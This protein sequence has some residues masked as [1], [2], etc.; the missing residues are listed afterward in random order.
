MAPD[1][2]IDTTA[3]NTIAVVSRDPDT[4]QILDLW[5]RH[6]GYAVCV[7]ADPDRVLEVARAVR[8]KLV[9]TNYPTL[10][11]SG[12]TVVEAIR[13]S[14]ELA[15][16]LVLSLTSH[17]SPHDLAAATTAGVDLSV[18]MPVPLSVLS[19]EVIRLIGPPAD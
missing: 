2:E 14:P 16:T 8:P 15:Q 18:P 12:D 17:V 1:V 13:G 11:S 10:L 3:T 6:L 4:R 7:V 9:I 5:L 19:D